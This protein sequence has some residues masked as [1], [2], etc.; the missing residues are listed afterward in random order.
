MDKIKTLEGKLLARDIRF[1]VVT[2]RFNDFIVT[3]LLDGALDTLRRHGA[4]E[5]DITVV[6]VPGAWE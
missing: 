3:P 5:A 2:A 6:R 4:V 1:G